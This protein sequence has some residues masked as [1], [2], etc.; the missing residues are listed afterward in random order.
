MADAHSI[1]QPA[2]P[3]L[4]SSLLDEEDLDDIVA[5]VFWG[6]ARRHRA[7]ERLG[8]GIRSVDHALGDGLRPGDVVGVSGCEDGGRDDVSLF[9]SF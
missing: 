3:I 2:A 1:P 8:T 4:A 5:S 6:R 7:G 9:L